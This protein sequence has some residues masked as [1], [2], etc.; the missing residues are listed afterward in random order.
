MP[1]RPDIAQSLDDRAQHSVFARRIVAGY[2]DKPWIDPIL[3]IV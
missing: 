3:D 2:R 1:A